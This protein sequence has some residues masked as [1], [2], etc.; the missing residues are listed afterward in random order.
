MPEGQFFTMCAHGMV[1]LNPMMDMPVS[2][3]G[4]QIASQMAQPIALGP[5]IENPPPRLLSSS[6]ARRD[7]FL[8]SSRVRRGLK[9]PLHD[10]IFVVIP[11][12][13]RDPYLTAFQC[14][15]DP[16]GS[17]GHRPSLACVGLCV[18]P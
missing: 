9:G 7:G 5:N 17:A 3:S 11:R 8:P 16:T 13:A 6:R 2:A 4:R 12:E 18:A 15:P 10:R 14:F 1:A